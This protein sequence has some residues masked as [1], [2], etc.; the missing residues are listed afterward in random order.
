MVKSDCSSKAEICKDLISYKN[1]ATII[2]SAFTQQNSDIEQINHDSESADLAKIATSP[3]GSEDAKE[4][5]QTI[6]SPY[7]PKKSKNSDVQRP[8]AMS[9]VSQMMNLTDQKGPNCFKVERSSKFTATLSKPTSFK[10][11]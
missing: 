6:S 1:F 2:P 5:D 4:K 3:I 9:N 7:Y 11:Q 8:I 10:I